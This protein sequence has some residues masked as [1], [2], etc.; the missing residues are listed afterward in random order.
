MT[1]MTA[2]QLIAMS[3]RQNRIVTE[4]PDTKTEEEELLDALR[5]RVDYEGEADDGGS[6]YDGSLARGWT[7]VWGGEDGDPWRV[8]VVVAP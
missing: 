6:G 1:T 4:Y 7:D 8:S 5:G 2:E 3:R